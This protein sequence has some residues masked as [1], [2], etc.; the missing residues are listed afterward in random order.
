MSSHHIVREKQEPALVIIDVYSI[1]AELVGQLLEWSPTLITDVDSYEA[2]TSQSYKV[3]LI[4]T[5][6]PIVL[7]Q[8]HVKTVLFETNFI[9]AALQYLINEGYGAVNIVGAGFDPEILNQF[10][11][12][13]DI[14]W[15]H[16]DNRTIFV[17]SGFEKWK[18]AGEELFLHPLPS[19]LETV[20]LEKISTNHFRTEKDGFFNI[21]FSI[22]NICLLTERL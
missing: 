22:P 16:E 7:P 1:D 5:K 4:F 13:I 21:K 18:S 12:H 11:E 9:E 14:V 8:E 3:D 6:E 20:G 19:D 2:V 10:S 17:H 15:L